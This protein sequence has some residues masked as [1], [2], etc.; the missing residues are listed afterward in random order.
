VIGALVASVCALALALGTALVVLRRRLELV[1]RAEHE[2]RGPATVV[3]LAAERMLRDPGA[4]RYAR[5]LELELERLRTAL[6]D[7]TAARRGRLANDRLAPVALERLLRGVAAGWAPALRSAGRRVRIDWEADVATVIADR[8]RLAQA[9]GNLMANAV[10]HGAGPV[11]LRGRRSGGA[12]RL[13]VR[14]GGRSDHPAQGPAG[15]GHGLAIARAAA[16][17]AGGELELERGE[18]DQVVAALV[19]PAEGADGPPAGT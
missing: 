4:R 12:V 6:A 7:L 3:F 17:S 16:E 13:E 18:E 11:E 2:I 15:R 19:L 5:A 9:L 14:N 10:D 8:G 1:A